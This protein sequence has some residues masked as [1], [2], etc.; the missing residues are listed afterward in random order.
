[1]G[2][3]EE[4]NDVAYVLG[5]TFAVLEKIQKEANPNVNTTIRDRYFNAACA[6]PASVFPILLKLKNSH[7]RK[8][9]RQTEGKKMSFEKKLAELMGKVSEFPKRLTLEE[10]GIFNLGYYHQV[11][12]IYEKREEK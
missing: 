9:E 12:K 4:T 11:Q 7:I 1:M 10:Q 6:N 3:N 2:L 5:R 8:I